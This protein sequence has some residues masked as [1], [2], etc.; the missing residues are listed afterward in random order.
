V[1][2]R[3]IILPSLNHPAF[4]AGRRTSPIDAGNLNRTAR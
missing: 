2:G 4:V 1:T 3:V